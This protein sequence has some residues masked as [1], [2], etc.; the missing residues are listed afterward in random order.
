EKEG[1]EQEDVIISLTPSIQEG[2]HEESIL[3]VEIQRKGHIQR[4]KLCPI[5][6][7]DSLEPREKPKRVM[8]TLGHED[9]YQSTKDQLQCLFNPNKKQLQE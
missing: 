2:Q 6:Y 4:T 8:P 1:K 7:L 3:G 9:E 5:R